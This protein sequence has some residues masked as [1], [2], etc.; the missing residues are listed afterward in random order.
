MSRISDLVSKGVR[1]IVVE[2]SDSP[3]PDEP[4]PRRART[5]AAEELVAEAPESAAQ[6]A[7]PAEVEDFGAVYAEARV[8]LPGHGYG[9]EKVAEMLESKR[10]AP[11]AREVR[12]TAVMA[13]LEA[14]GAPVRD[15]I[16]DAVRRDQVLDAF[17]TAKRRELDEKRAANEARIQAL[18]DEL[19]ALLRR[20]NDEVERLKRENGEAALAFEKLQERKRREEQRLFDVVAHFVEGADNPVSAAP[21]PGGPGRPPPEPAS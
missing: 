20:I 3:T 16:Q 21:Q 10:L 17:E 8:A 13:A 19:Q 2:T 5:I 12:A 7:V 18:Q 14:A 4:R 9:V 11:L 6:S 1:L 15:V